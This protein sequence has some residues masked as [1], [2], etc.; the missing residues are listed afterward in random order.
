MKLREL[1]LRMLSIIFGV[2]FGLFIGIIIFG[3]LIRIVLN[4]IFHWGDS[5]PVWINWLIT[6]LTVVFVFIS[7]YIFNRQMNSSL[8]KKSN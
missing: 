7:A 1:L 6:A 3:T 4:L 2:C 5:G 8:R